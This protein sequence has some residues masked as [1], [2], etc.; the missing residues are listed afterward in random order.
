MQTQHHKYTAG[1]IHI[2][3]GLSLVPQPI[4][5]ELGGRR[6]AR[7]GGANISPLDVAKHHV[8]TGLVGLDDDGIA[9]S[10]VTWTVRISIEP[11]PSNVLVTCYESQ[12]NRKGTRTALT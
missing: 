6:V 8:R 2:L 5:P 10:G 7:E 1:A 11:V 4:P 12:G 3:R 9:L